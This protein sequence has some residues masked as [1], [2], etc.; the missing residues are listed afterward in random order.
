MTL[1]D[2]GCCAWLR[3][4]VLR[5]PPE[6]FWYAACVQSLALPSLSPLPKGANGTSW[7]WAGPELVLGPQPSSFCST[8]PSIEKLAGIFAADFSTN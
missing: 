4:Q 2:H 8:Q 7:R 6:N 5:A 3:L 1:L